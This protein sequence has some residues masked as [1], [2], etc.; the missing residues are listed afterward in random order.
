[1]RFGKR[2]QARRITPPPVQEAVPP[3]PR[4]PMASFPTS[5]FE[6]PPMAYGPDG[7]PTDGYAPDGSPLGYTPGQPWMGPG[8]AGPPPMGYPPGGMPGYPPDGQPWSGEQGQP[9]MGE[10]PGGFPPMAYAFDPNGGPVLYRPDVPPPYEPAEPPV[11]EPAE[12]PAYEPAEPQQALAPSARMSLTPKPPQVLAEPEPESAA[13]AL[14]DIP[15]WPDFAPE[16]RAEAMDGGG[17]EVERLPTATQAHRLRLGRPVEQA[18]FARSAEVR[19]SR[20]HLRG[21]M[22]G[23]ARAS[24]EHLA[25]TGSLDREAFADLAEARWRAGDVDGAAEAAEAHLQARGDEPIA[26]VIAAEHAARE[27]RILDARQLATQV[28][29]QVGDGLERLFAAEPRS[30]VWPPAAPGWMDAHAALPGRYGLLVGGA[31][32][33][34]PGPDTWPTAP[35][36]SDQRRL[37]APS[38]A[39]VHTSQDA[40]PFGVS[41][42]DA[43]ER[44]REVDRELQAAERDLARG[45]LVALAD[46]LGLLLRR[47]PAL[48]PVIL[49][50]TE[51]A[52]AV[53]A[54]RGTQ[55][56]TATTGGSSGA[57]GGTP[58]QD[59]RPRTEPGVASLQMLRGDIH[60]S[61][62]HEADATQAY[63]QALRALPGRAITRES[64]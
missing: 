45:D 3:P 28:H 8:P 12:P 35:T 1:M 17:I 2:Q 46:R 7:S 40:A 37:P 44:S 30:A 36:D 57:V 64:T 43:A 41:V 29:G 24:L 53:G 60:R 23:L 63:Q 34:D 49:S 59:T 58:T 62:G 18:S 13:D 19:L 42:Q 61:L 4:L 39:L 11:Y 22:L 32:V 20:L 5:P 14:D 31:E 52:L 54:E 55:D 33:A 51:H 6:T 56:P 27:G 47:D 25:G 16:R 48:A 10:A 50:V 15:L 21:G 9:W 38:P 26:R